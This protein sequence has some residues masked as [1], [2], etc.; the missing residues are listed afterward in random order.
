VSGAV[1]TPSKC[2]QGVDIVNLTLS[3]YLI[4]GP[5]ENAAP[6]NVWVKLTALHY[7]IYTR[8]PQFLTNWAG[9][10]WVGWCVG[11]TIFVR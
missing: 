2:L 3:A 1:L 5:N 9:D 6:S 11:L 8:C 4:S 7:I 10:K